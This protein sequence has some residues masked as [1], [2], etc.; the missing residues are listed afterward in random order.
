MAEPLS[1]ARHIFLTG[2]KQVGKSTLWQRLIARQQLC[3]AGFETQLLMLEGQRRGFILHGRVDM[4]PASNDCIV[5]VRTGPRKSVPVLDVFNE[6]GVE[7]LRRSLDSDAPFLLMDELGKLE[8]QAE[9]FCS[10]VRLCLDSEKRVLGVLQQCD[11]PLVA[12]IATRP[13][14]TLLRVTV[15]N[16]EA[17]LN[18]LISGLTPAACPRKIREEL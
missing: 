18:A 11:S 15:D 16:R 7:I 5:S 1:L 14:V 8:R 13:D 9:A 17:L 10:Q 3:C 6:N 4:D 12:E 2:E